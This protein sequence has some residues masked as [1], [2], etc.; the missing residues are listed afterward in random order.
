MAKSKNV[1][2]QDL[3]ARLRPY[4][5]K[6]G[7]VSTDTIRFVVGSGTDRLPPG[8]IEELIALVDPTNKGDVHGD[9]LVSKLLPSHI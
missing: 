3:S 2:S 4:L 7:T 9:E 1:T 8:D 6:N 5:D